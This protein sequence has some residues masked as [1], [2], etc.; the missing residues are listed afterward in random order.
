MLPGAAR[1]AGTRATSREFAA[2]LTADCE[3]RP[4]WV[5]ER[6]AAHR[7]GDQVV[8]GAIV[9]AGPQRPWAWPSH[10]EFGCGGRSSAAP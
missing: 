3:A 6:L 9:S 1:N 8:A 2:F 10:Y 5:A 4:R 7:D